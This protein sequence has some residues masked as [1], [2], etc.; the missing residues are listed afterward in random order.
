MLRCGKHAGRSNH[1]VA[2]HDPWY[3]AW[4]LRERA[5]GRTLPRDLKT[6]AKFIENEYGGVMEVMGAISAAGFKKVSLM[7]ELPKLGAPKTAT[8]PQNNRR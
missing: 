1:E 6:L 5:Q 8:R 2:V 4:V 7:A 3:C